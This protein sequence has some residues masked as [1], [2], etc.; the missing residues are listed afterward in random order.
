VGF[1]VVVAGKQLFHFT[2]VKNDLPFQI[3]Y[4]DTLGQPF[5]QGGQDILFSF[6]ICFCA[7]Q[8]TRY[9]LFDGGLF[10]GKLIDY[11]GQPHDIEA[12]LNFVAVFR[13]D[14]NYQMGFFS[15]LIDRDNVKTEE[16]I[17]G[18][19][20]SCKKQYAGHKKVGKILLENGYED[21][22]IDFRKLL[23]EKNY[24]GKKNAQGYRDG[25]GNEPPKFILGL[26]PAVIPDLVGT[27]ILQREQR[28][29]DQLNKQIG[30]K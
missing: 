17:Q 26:Q 7:L 24:N 20:K 3:A 8:L 30:H 15:Q 16:P 11:L 29:G 10:I 1:L 18:E 9:G 13:I 12:A 21:F 5:Q 27:A 6:G 2:I 22:L 4:Q 28:F 23:P 25:H 14:R 19:A